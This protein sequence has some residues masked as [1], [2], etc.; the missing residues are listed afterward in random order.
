MRTPGA[1]RCAW[2]YPKWSERYASGTR[3]DERHN[4]M[5]SIHSAKSAYRLLGAVRIGLIVL[6]CAERPEGEA[7]T[8]KTII[9]TLFVYKYTYISDQSIYQYDN[10]QKTKT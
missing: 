3:T 2:G 9:Y 8:W 7:Q 4:I 6:M 10:V 5:I 1:H